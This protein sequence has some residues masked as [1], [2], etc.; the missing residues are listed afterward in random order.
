[1]SKVKIYKCQTCDHF[2]CDHPG[3]QSFTYNGTEYQVYRE[4]RSPIR[5][6]HEEVRQKM[7]SSSKGFNSM[8]ESQGDEQSLNQ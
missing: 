8:Q 5:L 4:H 6:I 3:K 1:M 7:R 2:H